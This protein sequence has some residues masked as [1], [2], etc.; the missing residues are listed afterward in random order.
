MQ[1]EWIYQFSKHNT[2]VNTNTNAS[3]PFV[4]QEV[5][6]AR[7]DNIERVSNYTHSLCKMITRFSSKLAAF[8]NF[9]C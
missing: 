6:K 8:P 3:D 1:F 5:Y 7:V 9:L 2:N 4:F